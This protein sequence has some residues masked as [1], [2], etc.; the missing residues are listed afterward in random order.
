MTGW[1]PAGKKALVVETTG[2]RIHLNI[3]GAMNLNDI[4]S[5]VIR[6]YDT[7]NSLSICQFFIAIREA[8]LI[9]QKVHIIFDGAGSPWGTGTGLGSS[10]EYSGYGK[11]QHGYQLIYRTG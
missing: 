8:Y 5:T 3:M 11:S 6:E 10:D 7:I 9:T 4:G 2:S 1:M